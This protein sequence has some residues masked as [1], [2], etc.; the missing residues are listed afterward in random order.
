MA[1]VKFLYRSTRDIAPITLRLSFRNDLKDHVI[2]S[3]TQITSTKEDWKLMQNSRRIKDAELKNK[4][5]KFDQDTIDIESHVLTAFNNSNPNLVNKLWLQ[6]QLDSYYGNNDKEV[7]SDKILEY[8]ERYLKLIENNITKTTHTR[9]NT[10][11]KF[12]MR[13]ISE[14]EFYNHNTLISDI[15]V[16]F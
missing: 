14:N 8:S 16:D 4:K 12:L 5:I 13:F 1:T 10:A 3:K 7:V 15:D 2:E 11:H 6:K 9:Y